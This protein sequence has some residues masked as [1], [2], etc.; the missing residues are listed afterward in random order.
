MKR[1]LK[2][3][4]CGLILCLAVS[5]CGFS[6][7]CQQ[8]RERVLRLHILAKSD[9]AEDQA[10]K[11]KVRDAVVEASAGLFDGTENAEEA[12]RRAEEKLPELLAVAQQVVAEEGYDYPV[13]VKL[14]HMY[15]TT[16]QYETVT[17]P[18][19]MYDAVRFTIGEGAGKNWWCV[20]FPPMCVSAAAQSEELGDVLDSR[21]EDIVTQPNKYEVR[22][23]SVEWFEGAVHALRSWFTGTDDST[24]ISSADARPKEEPRE[25]GQTAARSGGSGEP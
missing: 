17:L 2:A 5:L 23:K 15:F 9:S 11:L 10:L 3:I 13:R 25:Q 24:A 18:A 1:W 12:L 14:C 8:I 21:Q 7:E 4:A 19:G 6:G 22:L 16:R 20:V